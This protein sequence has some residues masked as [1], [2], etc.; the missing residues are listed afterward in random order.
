MLD[1]YNLYVLNFINFYNT[2]SAK[3]YIYV[4]IILM[5]N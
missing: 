2:K 5:Q 1:V 4:T 3:E